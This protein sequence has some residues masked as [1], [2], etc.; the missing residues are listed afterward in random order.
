MLR[1]E[2]TKGFNPI[3]LFDQSASNSTLLTEGNLEREC[4]EESC[5]N[6][7]LSETIDNDEHAQVIQAKY[8]KCIEIVDQVA[9]V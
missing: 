8:N 7:E 4:V 9:Q 3:L 6:E 5:T 1:W 2:E